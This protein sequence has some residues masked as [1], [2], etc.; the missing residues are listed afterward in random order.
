MFLFSLCVSKKNA[1]KHS[2]L[3]IFMISLWSLTIVCVHV[4]E[5]DNLQMN[6]SI[7]RICFKNVFCLEEKYT[8]FKI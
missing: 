2:V 3:N 6:T 7:L 5:K 1:L 4:Q 8:Q